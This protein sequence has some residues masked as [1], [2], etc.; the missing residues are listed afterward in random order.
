MLVTNVGG[1][2]EIVPHG[3]VGYTV[4]TNES[5]IADALIDFFENKKNDEFISNIIKEKKKYTWSTMT[6]TINNLINHDNKK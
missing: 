2:S 4:N 5:D 3:R 6:N 1:L